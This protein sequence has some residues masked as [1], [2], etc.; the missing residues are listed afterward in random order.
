M[1]SWTSVSIIS[2]VLLLSKIHRYSPNEILKANDKQV[3][4]KRL[5][6]HFE[7]KR[8]IDYLERKLNGTLPTHPSQDPEYKKVIA[9]QYLEVRIWIRF[10]KVKL[11]N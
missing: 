3:V 6:V 11:Y 9:S 5:D 8:V 10:L 7:P 2:N 4:R 1:I